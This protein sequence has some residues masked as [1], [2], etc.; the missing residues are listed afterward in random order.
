MITLPDFGLDKM[1]S[2][3]TIVQA[4][5]IPIPELSMWQKATIMFQKKNL[6]DCLHYSLSTLK[7]QGFVPADFVEQ[8]VSWEQITHHSTESL[9]DFGFVWLDM[10][11]MNFLPHH[12]KLLEWSHL[13]QL[14]IKSVNMLETALSIHDL[15]A[16]RLS[17]QQLHQLGWT[18]TQITDIGGTKD[19]INIAAS[20]ISIYFSNEKKESKLPVLSKFKF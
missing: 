19:N 8:G 17:P 6:S 3:N 1:Q 15:I 5:R 11:A 13:H 9:L 20:D 7:L 2:M 4:R 10:I 14:N 18:W 12:F 16:L